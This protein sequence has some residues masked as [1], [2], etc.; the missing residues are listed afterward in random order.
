MANRKP[1]FLLHICVKRVRRGY[2]SFLAVWTI[3]LAL[4]VQQS[5]FARITPQLTSRD[6]S[7]DGLAPQAGN[8]FIDSNSGSKIVRVTD[9]RDGQAAISS[10]AN[11]SSF[12]LNS[13]RFIVNLDGAPVLYS[14][15]KLT[16]EIQKQLQLASLNVLQP[17][18][19]RWSAVDPNTIIG[20]DNTGSARLFAY[21]TNSGSKTVLKDFSNTLGNGEASHLSKAWVDDDRFAFS[22]G[23]QNSRASMVVVW[24]RASDNT[25]VFYVNDPISGV[26]G[27]T[28][29]HLD[30]AGEA[31]IVNG[32]TTRVWR[33]RTSLQSDS[34]QIE[35]AEARTEIIAEGRQNDSF[36]LFSPIGHPSLLPRNNVSPDGRFSIF[37]SQTNGSRSDVFIAAVE[38]AVTPSS[39]TWANMVNCSS[40]GNSLQKTGGEDMADKERWCGLNNSNEIHHSAN[41]INYAIKLA[42]NK[43]ALV[44][45]NGVVK[46]KIKYKP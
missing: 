45:E 30:K 1:H 20:L 28:E 35:N 9:S 42:G 18:S 6:T 12:N 5:A 40:V 7:A 24:D 29:A 16:L 25:F 44:V 11:F 2:P 32:D 10:R 38:S 13:S 43:K 31:L 36:E 34:V 8:I 26:A 15:A 46:A 41:D 17:D 14:I 21:D 37:S 23:D 4:L 22:W 39:I 27:F 3:I 33:Y 19:I